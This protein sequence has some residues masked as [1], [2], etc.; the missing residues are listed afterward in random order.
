MRGAEKDLYA[1]LFLFL[2][3]ALAAPDVFLISVDTLRADR[4]AAYGNTQGTTPA[5]DAFSKEARVFG[6][7]LCEIP[8][9]G[10][11]FCSMMTSR[12]PRMLGVVQNGQPLADGLPTIAM[13]FQNAGYQTWCIQSN[14]P[15]RS[16]LCGLN[17]GFDRYDDGFEQERPGMPTGERYA[18]EVTKLALEALQQRDPKRPLFL[19]VHYTDPHAP[20]RFHIDFNPGG[21]K[22]L[23]LDRAAQ[24]RVKYD[25]EVAFADHHIGLL[26]SAIPKDNTVVLFVADHGES[27]FDHGYLGHGRRINQASMHVP[28]IIRG[29]AV[30]P[31]RIAGPAR[32][33]DVG[34][35]LLALA[36]LPPAPG[37]IGLNLLDPLP[38]ERTRVI[39]TYG[40]KRPDYP[41]QTE[42]RSQNM[43]A[44]ASLLWQGVVSGEWKLVLS[45][46]INPRPQLFNLHD[47]PTEKSDLAAGEPAR[48]RNLTAVI[49]K[50]NTEIVRGSPGKSNLSE[51]DMQVLRALGYLQ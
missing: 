26:L 13:M 27:L 51:E 22:L 48:V 6:D 10:P 39:E 21:R 8:L 31:G 36:G 14:W 29:P 28:L 49:K 33:I 47:D 43:A 15:L 50:W 4:L 41:R 34:P 23:G 38:E 46:D 35:T 40:N 11:S 18:D 30:A 42:Y 9:T 12:Y 7:C 45:A 3:A 24:T 2:T 17:R 32:G 1:V 20:Y 5:L 19:W 44:N 37:M 16:Y 25:S